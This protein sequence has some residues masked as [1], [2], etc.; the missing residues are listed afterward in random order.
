MFVF[1]VTSLCAFIR[2][3]I[4]HYFVKN[5]FASFDVYALRVASY[6]ACRTKNRPN[7]CFSD[8]N[9]AC[10]KGT[11]PLNSPVTKI[12]NNNKL[13][14]IHEALFV[15]RSHHVFCINALRLNFAH[16]HARTK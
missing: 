8:S 4:F 9:I 7:V 1:V 2:S 11:S 12:L 6:V 3:Y 5:E 13:A 16:D 14:V 10:Q 15:K